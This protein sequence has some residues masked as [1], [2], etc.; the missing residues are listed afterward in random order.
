MPVIQSGNCPINVKIDGSDSA[1]ALIMSNS[2]GTNLGMWDP[3]AQALSKHFRLV[4]YDRRG[5]GQ[6]GVPTPPYTMEMLGRDVLA[7]EHFQPF[8][9]VR[10]LKNTVSGKFEHAGERHPHDR[11]VVDHQNGLELLRH[12]TSIAPRS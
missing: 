4:R 3:Q 10:G 6:S 2:L 11:F 9:A 8:D 7:R 12:A 5:H 1:P